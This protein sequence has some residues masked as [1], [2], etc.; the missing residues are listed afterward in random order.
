MKYDYC[1]LSAFQFESLVVYLCF[2]LFGMGTQS[3]ADGRDGGRDSRFDGL[4]N[5]YPSIP[6]PWSGLTI[7]QAK[8]TINHNR[9][10]SDPD[11][12]G[13]VTSVLNEEIPKIKKLL[14]TDKMDNYLLFANRRLPAEANKDILDFISVETG[15]NKSNIGLMGIETME[16]Y[17]KVYPDVPEMAGLNP[18]DV[19]INIDPE[20]LAEVIVGINS[21]LGDLTRKKIESHIF[22]VDFVEKNR[23]NKLGVSYAN[24][25]KKKIAEITE[26]SDFLS[27]PDNVVYQ[28]KYIESAEELAAKISVFKKEHHDFERVLEVVI[29]L[30]IA[31]DSDLY[32]NKKLT[33]IMVY[34]MYYNCDIGDN[35]ELAS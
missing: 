24:V 2:K 26:I 11:F 8:H 18:F 13:N 30:L 14:I 28:N 5:E 12:Y 16:R 6:K 3:F 21:S 34:Y 31:R 10:F 32:R 7:I 20:Q 23:I 4:A 1:G 35:C 19:L 33:R 25:I 15:L 17:F 22:R 9:K 27:H 29:E